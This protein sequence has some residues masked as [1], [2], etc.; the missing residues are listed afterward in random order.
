MTRKRPSFRLSHLVMACAVGLGQTA[1]ASAD[2]TWN[3]STLTNPNWEISLTDFGYSDYLLDQTP[4]FEGRE[5][6]SGEWGAAISYSKGNATTSPTWMEPRFSF[7]NWDTNSN[8]SVV[9][10][11]SVAAG[12]NGLPTASSVIGNDDL[13]IT[14]NI[15]FVDT[16][17]G[18]PMGWSATSAGGPGK[19]LSSNRYVMLQNYSITNTGDSYISNLQFFQLVHGLTSQSGVFDNRAY[20]GQLADFRYDITLGGDASGGTAQYDYI[21]LSSRTAPSAIEVG[22]FGIEGVDDH[23]IGKPGVGTHLSVEANSLSGVDSFSPSTPWVAGAARWNLASTLAPGETANMEVMLTILTGWQVDS[24]T[25]SG[26]GNGGGGDGILP[27]GTIGYEFLGNH[28][29]GQFFFGYE[30]EDWSSVLE[31]VQLGEFGMPTFQAPGG[32]LQ[33]FEVEFEGEFEG[34]IKLTFSYDSAL[35]PVGFDEGDLRLYH[36][37]GSTWEDLGGTVDAANDTITAYTDNLSPFAVAAAVPEPE[38]YALLLAGLGLI[39]LRLKQCG[40][41]RICMDH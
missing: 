29:S 17:V 14:Q 34:Q 5:Y 2:Y 16:L 35:L 40:G 6:L 9:Q 32:D 11:M 21:G 20:A 24:S 3:W 19:A 13:R 38:T 15:S 37:N 18:T 8:F 33:L 36:W 41:N 39:G 4:G 7:P 12:A 22:Y 30:A 31:M 25:E 28:S 26:I 1:A 27:P 10:A 23:G